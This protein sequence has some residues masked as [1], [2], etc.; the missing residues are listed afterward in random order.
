MVRGGVGL[1]FVTCVNCLMEQC[2]QERNY[3]WLL[4]RN[5]HDV[6]RLGTCHNMIWCRVGLSFI[7]WVD[8]SMEQLPG[9]RLLASYYENSLS[10]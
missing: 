9:A 1:N 6:H 3:V 10:T 4:Y 7:T 8:H 5:E 2:Y